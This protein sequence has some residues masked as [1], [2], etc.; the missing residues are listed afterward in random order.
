[1]QHTRTIQTIQGFDLAHASVGEGRPVVFIHGAVTTLDD[2][3]IA[4]RPT[5]GS[6]VRLIAFDRPGHGESDRGPGTGSA[7]RQ[8][9]LIHVALAQLGVE[10][11]V[12]VG[13][14]F[15][16]A[17]A[18]A[19]ALKYPQALS[20]VVAVA[21]IAFPEPRLEQMIFGL[22]G[23]PVAG[24]W[25]AQMAQPIDGVLLPLMWEGMFLPQAMPL[26]FRENFPFALAGGREQLQADGDD[27]AL[28][29]ASLTRN[30]LHYWTCKVPVRV[31][32]GDRDIVVNP[33]LHGRLLGA[34]LPRGTFTSLPGLG[35]MAHHF[36]PEAVADAIEALFD[37]ALQ[38][39][40]VSVAG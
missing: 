23:L 9:E 31:L 22:R 11:P 39:R 33:A 14:S 6:R 35:H 38:D 28:M 26:A 27:A 19:Y 40:P 24:P 8:A 4:L 37:P 32:Q 10:R 2:G 17:V 20:G 7:W 36:A 29:M 12:L 13:H 18:L 1:M 5:L 30:A 21:P 25:V 16:G 34:V 15:G 3:L